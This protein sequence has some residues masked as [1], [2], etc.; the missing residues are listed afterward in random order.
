MSFSG[1]IRLLMG[2]AGLCVSF[3][4]GSV[5]AC[6]ACFGKSDSSL[7]KGMNWGI[8]SLLVLVIGVLGGI[9]SFFIYIA[10]KSAMADASTS[11]NPVESTERIP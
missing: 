6:A 5:V 9:A 7:A 4:P 2:F 11:G 3:V 10:R 1:V 8:A